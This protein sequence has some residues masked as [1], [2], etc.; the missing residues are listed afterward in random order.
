MEGQWGREKGKKRKICSDGRVEKIKKRGFFFD[1]CERKSGLECKGIV[2]ASYVLCFA[3]L[4]SI[5]FA[6]I[7]RLSF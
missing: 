6:F 4:L 5:P 2:V 7:D 1:Y 3:I